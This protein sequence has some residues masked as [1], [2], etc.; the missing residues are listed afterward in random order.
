MTEEIWMDSIT[1]KGTH[2]VSSHGRVKR[3]SRI[4]N[5]SYG[6]TRRISERIC[7]HT[8]MDGGYRR[9]NLT[10]DGAMTGF[11]IHRLVAEV[12]VENPKQL[13][14]VNHINGIKIDNR[15]E[16]LE[17]CTHAENMRHAFSTGLVKCARAV[18]AKYKPVGYWFPSMEDAVKSTRVSKPCIC[19]AAKKRQRTAGGVEWS[20]AN[21]T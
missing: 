5:S 11:L 1:L 7:E 3:L 19:A 8:P 16:N 15:P 18:V 14:F 10:I 13:P 9:I 4:V 20:Y 21:A 17:W 12:F 2:M 6:A